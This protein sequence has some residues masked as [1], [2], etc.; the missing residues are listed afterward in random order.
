MPGV[1]K[2]CFLSLALT[3]VSQPTRA[4]ASQ[5]AAA[6]VRVPQTCEVAV[7]TARRASS[8]ALPDV[9]QACPVLTRQILWTTG[10]GKRLAISEWPAAM[11]ARLLEFFELIDTNASSLRLQCPTTSSVASNRTDSTWVYATAQQAFDIYAAHVAHALDLEIRGTVPWSL[12]GMPVDEAAEI[13]SSDRYFA[14]IVAQDG[15]IYPAAIR[16]GRDFQLPTRALPGGDALVCD[17]R[18][19]ERFIRGET[20]TGHADLLGA[21][22]R[23]TLVR[24]TWWLQQNVYH[25]PPGKGPGGLTYTAPALI[26]QYLQTRLRA[27]ATPTLG[28]VILASYGCHSV[29]NLLYDLAKSVNIPLLVGNMLTLP[30]TVKFGVAL[31]H[32]GVAFHW[33]RSDALV[34]HH[35]DDLYVADGAVP[36]V[37]G[38]ALL[39]GGDA[40]HNL[41]AAVWHSPQYWNAHHFHYGAKHGDGYLPTQDMDGLFHLANRYGGLPDAGWQLGYWDQALPADA[42]AHTSTYSFQ[43]MYANGYA[44]CSWPQLIK[45]YCAIPDAT[46]AQFLARA[47]SVTNNFPLNLTSPWPMTPG[48]LYRRASACVVSVGG[49]TAAQAAVDRWQAAVGSNVLP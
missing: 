41:F 11:R 4:S 48:A 47:R 46:Q 23:E 5:T 2:V 13:L 20:S 19:G 43:S 40:P 29:A 18:I 12:R 39:E 7:A 32:A 28:R 16:P 44:T 3:F 10:D 21:T 37:I 9:L 33:M 25:D 35:A 22:D 30:P 6:T 1:L 36:S 45:P 8:I 42:A 14:R 49:C 27:T 31:E 17:P 15:T 24:L 34:V 38:P 26:Q